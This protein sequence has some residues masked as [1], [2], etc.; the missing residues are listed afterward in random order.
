MTCQVKRIKKTKYCAGDLRHRIKFLQRTN[1]DFST[2]LSGLG[3]SFSEYKTT[4]AGVKTTSGNVM[5]DGVMVNDGSTHVF[6]M[7][8][9]PNITKELFIEFK[10]YVYDIADIVNLEERDKYLEVRAKKG[11]LRELYNV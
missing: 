4:K 2:S 8:Y 5:V 7:R 10:G 9:T 3:N 6:V 11:R 1:G